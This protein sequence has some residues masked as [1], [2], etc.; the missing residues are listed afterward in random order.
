MLQRVTRQ[1]GDDL[2]QPVRVP[3]AGRVASADHV[4]LALRVRRVEVLQRLLHDNVQIG[5]LAH[6][7]DATC[8]TR[9][10]HVE[11]RPDAAR[12]AAPC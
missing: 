11:H 1:I 9:A 6:Q 7:H 12:Y 4:N 3:V 2:Q 10:R 5:S 8:K